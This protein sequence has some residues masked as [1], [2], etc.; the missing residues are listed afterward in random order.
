L[1]SPKFQ[2]QL[3]QQ[4]PIDEQLLSVWIEEE[5]QGV[6]PGGKRFVEFA[7]TRVDGESTLR[8]AP[9]LPIEIASAERIEIWRFADEKLKGIL[10]RVGNYRA[11]RGPRV[12]WEPMPDEAA[13]EQVVERLNQWL[14]LQ[15]ADSAWRADRLVASLPEELQ[16]LV[17]TDALLQDRFDAY[18]GR[19]LQEAVWLRDISNWARGD[20][21]NEVERARNLFDWTVRN[22]LLDAEPAPPK[23]P[24]QALASGRATAWERAWVFALLCRQQGLD[25]VILAKKT[26]SDETWNDWCAALWSDG[27]FYLF[28]PQLGLPLPGTDP[29]GVATLEEIAADNANS[30]EIHGDPS[31]PLRGADLERVVVRIVA[32]PE[33]LSRRMHA[34]ESRLAGQRGLALSVQP[35]RLAEELGGAERVEDVGLWEFPYRTVLGQRS[36]DDEQRRRLAEEFEVFAWQPL[37]WKARVLHFQGRLGGEG[38]AKQYYRQSRPSDQQ[39]ARFE[40]TSPEI[41][42]ILRRAKLNASYWLGL[43][44]FDEG[45]AEVSLDYLRNRCGNSSESKPWAGGILY[46]TARALERLGREQEARALYE[47]DRS[48]QRHGN[49]LRARW[50]DDRPETAQGAESAEPAKQ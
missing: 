20:S 3:R 8:L 1:T 28:D 42:A 37:L 21:I 14:R 45:H 46:N 5:L 16:K 25:I 43:M 30:K 2:Q 41:V 9:G 7:V 34:V 18:D 13:L 19:L 15:P 44:M 4:Q 12:G 29:K 35:S 11:G 31:H 50:F 27:E 26:S 10:R 38:G 48:P 47:A 6:G 24:W 17:A 36:S 22:I 33:D 32:S 39:L 40:E 49:H 23:R